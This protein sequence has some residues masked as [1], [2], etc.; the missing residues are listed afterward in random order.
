MAYEQNTTRD[1]SLIPN[2]QI[3]SMF[4]RICDDD[5]MTK[6]ID[7]VEKGHVSLATAYASNLVYKAFYALV[8]DFEDSTGI[9]ATELIK[10]KKQ[11]RRSKS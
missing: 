9:K 5:Q 1:D 2:T 10:L 4:M 6:Y 11:N 3:E 7:L 8:E